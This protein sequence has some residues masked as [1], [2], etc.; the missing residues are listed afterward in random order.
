MGRPRMPSRV[1]FFPEGSFDTA[2]GVYGT[3]PIRVELTLSEPLL[4]APFLSLTPSSG[5]PIVVDL[6]PVAGG[7][8]NRYQGRMVI[9]AETPSGPADVLMSGRDAVGNRGTGI[10]EGPTVLRL[11]TTGPQVVAL[12]VAPSLAIRNDP[13]SP[14]TVSFTA[15]LDSAVR[16]GT[17]P[18]FRY[19]LTNSLPDSVSVTS[20]EAGAD[21]MTWVVRVALAGS[22]GATTEVLEL[23]FR[24]EDALGNVGTRILPIHRFQVYQG[25][26]PTLE[27]PVGLVAKSLPAGRVRLTWQAVPKAA[28][29]AVFRRSASPADFSFVARTS[30]ATEWMDLPETDGSYQY[31]V[32]TVRRENGQE[33]V[34]VQ[35]FVV[36][37]VSD[38][39]PPAAP[40]NLTLQLASNGVFAKWQVPPGTLETITYGLVRAASGSITTAEGVT[41]Y[42]ERIAAPQVVDPSPAPNE[43]FYAAYAED[44]AGN[45]S[46]PSNTEYLNVELLPVRTLAAEQTDN[47]SPVIRW[48]QASPSA[49]GYD[50]YLGPDS[51]RLKLN[52]QG[53][54][55]QTSFTDS[56]YDGND[57]RY[58][59]VTLDA[60]GHES[61]GRSLILPRVEW[62][63]APESVVRRGLM[64]R[65]L[66]T[67]WNRSASALE[68]AQLKLA[69]GGKDHFSEPFT[70]EPG[71][72]G[73]VGVVVG[74]YANLP[75]GNAPL[76]L[77]L[78]NRPNEGEL[79]S[80]SRTGLVSVGDGQLL[81]G[82]LGRDLTRG[83]SG[84]VQF[85]LINPGGV[86]IEVITSRGGGQSPDIR[87]NLL[88]ADGNV[89][90]SA[91][92]QA[93]SGANIVNLSNGDAVMRLSPGAEGLSPSF[94]MSVPESAPSRIFVQVQIDRVYYHSDQPDRVEMQGLQSRSEVAVVDTTYTGAVTSVVPVDSTGEQVIQIFG[95]A[96][97]RASGEPA[98]NVPLLVKIA[99]GGF[100]RTDTVTTDAAGAFV[101]T[102]QP[103]PGESGGVYSVWAVH[104]E[105]RDRTVQKTFTIRRVVVSPSQF[106]VRAPF[107]FAQP[108]SLR[109]NAGPG[110]TA[111][112]LRIVARAEDQPNRT[113]PSGVEIDSGPVIARLEPGKSATL[114]PVIT[115]GEG[116]AQRSLVILAVMSDDNPNPWQI[117]TA[118]L[119]FAESTP[120]LRWGPSVVETGVAPDS[121]VSAQ[122][123]LENVGLVGARD[124]KFAITRNDGSPAP[125]WVT[126]GTAPTLAELSVGG[127]FEIGLNFQPGKSV[128][129]DD[130]A[131][132][133]QITSANHPQVNVGVYVAVA[134]SGKGNL[135]FRVVDMF[136]GTD[137]DG[138]LQGGLGGATIRVQN[139]Q[140]ESIELRLTSDGNGEALFEDLPAGRYRYQVTA[141]EHNG[142]NGRIWVRPKITATEQVALAYSL[143]TVEWEVVPITIEDRYEIVLEAVFKT[144][145]PA[146]V[147]VIEPSVV[148]LPQLFAG[149]VF[150]GEFS[151]Q[152]HGLI[153]ADEFTF[154]LPPSD[155]YLEYE[156]L[157]GLPDQLNAK[158]RLRVP[159]R[160][161]C[162]KSLPGPRPEP[163]TSPALTAG[164]RDTDQRK[165][166][167]ASTK[168]S[169][170]SE[171]PSKA[172]GLHGGSGTADCFTYNSASKCRYVYRCD[173]GLKFPG[174]AGSGWYYNYNKGCAVSS[175]GPVT[176][177]AWSS[178]SSGSNPKGATVEWVTDM[179]VPTLECGTSSQCDTQCCDGRH[180]GNSWVDLMSREYRDEITDLKVK[181]PGGE[182]SVVRHFFRNA[183]QWADTAR[184][185]EL[186]QGA[187]G[188]LQIRRWLIDY[189]PIN[190]SRTAFAY[191][192]IRITREVDGWRWENKD[193]DWEFY[194]LQG[195]ILATGKR[196]L[197]LTQFVYAEGG[198]LE[199]V[200]DRNDRNRVHLPIRRRATG[201]RA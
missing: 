114:A 201:G 88:D 149:D 102:F 16:D 26:L 138:N 22:A 96:I 182:A 46:I 145:V 64:N 159:Y 140:V 66:V 169:R 113:F 15:R 55:T 176:F 21:A 78:E 45:R 136:T 126:L 179:C 10:R 167:L 151:I 75:D 85:S 5:M 54:L 148:N 49:T 196:N 186:I 165:V 115:A 109:A 50:L 20:V 76:R 112:N 124:L 40:R 57:R 36:P 8:P 101:T 146:P 137:A 41:P 150:Y 154:E 29:Y 143:V 193:G 42:R 70:L 72:S 139:E 91:P 155:D 100:E 121:S 175:G 135:L 71:T 166:R 125:A 98:T 128:A 198:R 190:S 87:F 119:E 110:T 53:P 17:T 95:G 188:I 43:G 118:N 185:L 130:Y 97:L 89:L 103:L 106:T 65:V 173:N 77:T 27:S 7:A 184:S 180:P 62:E 105:L 158:Q 67:V 47:L 177:G 195:R 83:G 24:A 117:L 170:S 178:P 131:F 134:T 73:P 164:R 187:E 31:V 168:E 30:S 59:V 9:T 69:L 156:L 18:E 61:L 63:F 12:D 107:N 189:R 58:T 68:S 32:A 172:L 99:N 160:I 34:G 86:E 133:L 19:R 90:G 81:V 191:R 79:A 92:F 141:D 80:L 163:T 93:R 142:A 111:V 192:E 120:A 44:A 13:A 14:V 94:T 171:T 56:G 39:V 200:T 3:G 123:N 153:R 152:N 116:S 11:D 74:G 51:A 162:K 181:V 199:A 60:T 127:R 38:R 35:S 37:A 28:D 4:A 2:T 129:E 157:A 122:V 161:L 84:T 33:S 82:V 147:V 23:E 174:G 183:W 197:V 25:E 52:P 1:E 104:P 144:D 48:T 132:T 108:L 194:S 6:S